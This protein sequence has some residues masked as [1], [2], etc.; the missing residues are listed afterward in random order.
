MS[1]DV[2]ITKQYILG[3]IGAGPFLELVQF[4]NAIKTKPI[5]TPVTDAAY[6]Q[7]YTDTADA[8]RPKI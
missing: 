3:L 7:W 1:E 4:D 2:I 5:I 6:G 8:N